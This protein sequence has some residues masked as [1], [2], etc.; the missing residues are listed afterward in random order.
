M[1]PEGLSQLVGG[2]LA[3]DLFVC[4]YP[5]WSLEVAFQTRNLAAETDVMFLHRP[6]TKRAES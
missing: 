4:W 3:C 1:V 6:Q 2:Q 5:G